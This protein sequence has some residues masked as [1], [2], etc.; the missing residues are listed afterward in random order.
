M[1]EFGLPKSVILR[2]IYTRE[3]P[4]ILHRR[5]A[6]QRDDLLIKLNDQITEL[7]IASATAGSAADGK[8][9]NKLF[10]EL[11]SQA[12]NLMPPI[13]NSLKTEQSHP[14]DPYEKLQRLQRVIA[15]NRPG[16]RKN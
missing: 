6:H 4:L 3:V 5:R 1:R 12:M 10:D 13:N 11:R 7:R 16:M 14:E 2:E 9:I 8:T 15:Q